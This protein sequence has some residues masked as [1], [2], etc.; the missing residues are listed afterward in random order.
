MND[1]KLPAPAVPVA[2]SVS[3]ALKVMPPSSVKVRV[4]KWADP[5][6]VVVRP[7]MLTVCSGA[8]AVVTLMVFRA[9]GSTITSP[10][11]AAVTVGKV[12][13]KV[14]EVV[15]SVFTGVDAAARALVLSVSSRAVSALTLM[16]ETVPH[17]V[18]AV[19][20]A[21]ITLNCNCVSLWPKARTVGLTGVVLFPALTD[22]A[23]IMSSC[24]VMVQ[25]TLLA[26]TEP[27]G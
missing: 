20:E 4:I 5:A 3:V 19:E 12:T 13:G 10:A 25:A 17:C 6:T 7:E 16:D 2:Q 14:P 11:S 22:G 26:D 27:E 18:T 21:A 23:T 24:P 9:P 15:R 1:Y 8:L